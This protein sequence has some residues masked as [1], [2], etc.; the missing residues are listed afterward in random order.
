MLVQSSRRQKT[1][2][3]TISNSENISQKMDGLGGSGAIS[4]V[5]TWCTT[6]QG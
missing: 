3:L 4:K 6:E 2:D 1:V 5:M